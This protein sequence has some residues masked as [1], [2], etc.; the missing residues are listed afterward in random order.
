M[1][2]PIRLGDGQTQAG[3][4]IASLLSDCGDACST[5]YTCLG[6]G[7]LVGNIKDAFNDEFAY[8]SVKVHYRDDWE[9]SLSWENLIKS[10]IDN[11]RPVLYYGD[12][13]IITNGH[14]FII[15]GYQSTDYCLFHV[16]F[17]HKGSSND[18]FYLGNIH[19]GDESYCHNQKAITGISP[20]YTENS[21]SAVNYSTVS[22]NHR[23]VARIS[24]QLPA[25]GD[26]LTVNNSVNYVVEAGNDVTLKPGFHALIGSE[27]A[28]RVN[29]KLQDTMAISVVEWPTILQ[30]GQS[31]CIHTHNA[32]SWE[33]MAFDVNGGHLYQ[34][35]GLITD[36]HPCVWDGTNIGTLNNCII[37]LKNSYGRSLEHSYW[38]SLCSGSKDNSLCEGFDYVGDCSIQSNAIFDRKK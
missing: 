34:S 5:I 7:A 17:G 9:T 8:K 4:D 10:E 2:M 6:S 14:Y 25:N 11:N 19:E 32:D 38:L 22:R 37:R 31:L 33:F 28:I 18:Y 24:I 26:T 16:N 30:P 36:D 12:K 29:Q 21:I 20:T 1:G 35:A 23:E 15:D 13:S 27:T 3:Y